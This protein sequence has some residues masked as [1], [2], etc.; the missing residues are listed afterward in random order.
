MRDKGSIAKRRSHV[1]QS[2]RTQD[3]EHWQKFQH[4]VCICDS[5]LKYSFLSGACDFFFVVYAIVLAKD[6]KDGANE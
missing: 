2:G 1:L 6:V 3:I 4:G 5:W